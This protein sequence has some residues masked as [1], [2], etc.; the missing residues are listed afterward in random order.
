MTAVFMHACARAKGNDF[1]C[2]TDLEMEPNA[3]GSDGKLR[4]A[5]DVGRRF[6]RMHFA[7]SSLDL[8]I[9]SEVLHG[10]NFTVL[11]LIRV[12]R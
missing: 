2:S 10:Y 4:Q 6:S 9:C 7:E 3:K 8:V 1:R 11:P 12:A 5:N